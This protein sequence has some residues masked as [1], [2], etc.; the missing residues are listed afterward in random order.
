[1]DNWGKFGETTLPPEEAFYSKLNLKDISNEDYAQAKK[2]WEVF[3]IKNCGVY[4]NLYAHSGTLLLADVFDNF[5]NMC[6]VC[7]RISMASLLKK[8]MSKIRI[9][10]RV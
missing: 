10:N 1:M 6:L 8:D 4:H 2:V 3:G 9:I 7:T 5:R